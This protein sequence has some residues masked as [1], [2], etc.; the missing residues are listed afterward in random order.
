MTAVTTTL[1]LNTIGLSSNSG[2]QG[3][4]VYFYS[5]DLP[6][7]V[8][9]GKWPFYTNSTEG[10]RLMGHSSV[11]FTSPVDPFIFLTGRVGLVVFV[12]S[13]GVDEIYCGTW[14]YKCRTFINGTG[15]WSV[16]SGKEMNIET[17]AEITIQYTLTDTRLKSNSTVLATIIVGT[18]LRGSGVGIR[19]G[20]AL[21]FDLIEMRFG[22]TLGSGVTPLMSSTGTS[23]T[24]RS[25]VL[26]QT[27]TSAIT[28]EFTLISVSVGTLTMTETTVVSSY[29]ITLS[30][31]YF[32]ITLST[33]GDV[34]TTRSTVK[35]V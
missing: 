3:K 27:G 19:N 30:G 21:Q 14:Q 5:P 6:F 18:G 17:S 4:D 16:T 13:T 8:T 9:T 10:E 29:L 15:H 26:C 1:T 7:T 34:S 22:T 33:T 2:Y 25:C 20:G 24:L 35:N 32:P 11:T 12:S 28:S 23:L 31:T